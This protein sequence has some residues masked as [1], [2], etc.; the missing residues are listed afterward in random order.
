MDKFFRSSDFMQQ[1]FCDD[2]TAHQ[3]SMMVEGILEA[4]SKLVKKALIRPQNSH[5]VR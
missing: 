5:A 2:H 3:A 1:L 4:R